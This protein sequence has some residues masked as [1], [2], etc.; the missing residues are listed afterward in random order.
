MLL[1]FIRKQGDKYYLYSHKN[2]K[3]LGRFAGYGSEKAA[4]KALRRISSH[5]KYSEK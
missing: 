4:K 3:K 2:G 1:E 5:G